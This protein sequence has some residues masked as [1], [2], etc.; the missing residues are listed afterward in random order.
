MAEIE[1]GAAA[2]AY[3]AFERWAC[4]SNVVVCFGP[5]TVMAVDRPGRRGFLYDEVYF[6]TIWASD[7]GDELV[8]VLRRLTEQFVVR[9][10]AEQPRAERLLGL[11]LAEGAPLD[12]VRHLI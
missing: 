7:G 10:P 8:E 2:R 1:F 6:V 9:D 11:V 3:E 5:D 4:A 12:E